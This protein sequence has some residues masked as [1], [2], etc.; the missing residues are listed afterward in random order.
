[1]FLKRLVNLLSYLLTRRENNTA[2]SD[3]K[4]KRPVFDV[5]KTRSKLNSL[6]SH[7]SWLQ[8]GVSRCKTYARDD[9]QESADE[10]I[11]PRNINTTFKV[12]RAGPSRARYSGRTFQLPAKTVVRFRSRLNAPVFEPAAVRMRTAGGVRFPVAVRTTL[13]SGCAIGL[14]GISLC[15]RVSADTS[16]R[17][18]G[19]V[20]TTPRRSHW[21][22][23][24]PSPP[25]STVWL[26]P[27]RARSYYGRK[28]L[29]INRSGPVLCDVSIDD[30]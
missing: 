20:V 30:S 8:L 22:P 13:L 18:P 7:F 28:L 3:S 10:Q 19:N 23:P 21:M 4:V 12:R 9:T 6:T 25:L 15:C 26:H 11:S 17:L 16:K 5:R 27:L 29:P 24:P 2:K 14:Q 1:L